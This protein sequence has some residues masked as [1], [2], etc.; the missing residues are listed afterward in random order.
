MQEAGLR[1]FPFQSV[2]TAHAGI[3]MSALIDTWKESQ[4][5]SN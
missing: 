2:L 4:M 1:A 5:R 3:G